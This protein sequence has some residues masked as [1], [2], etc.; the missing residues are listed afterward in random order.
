MQSLRGSIDG[1]ERWVESH[2]YKAYEPFDGLS[3]YL[4]PLTFGNRVLEQILLQ[5]GRQSPIN[6]RPL[7]GIKP[8]ESTKGR[9]Y[10]AWG[11][12]TLLK[13]TGRDEYR[14][15]A[16][17]CLEWLIRN[18]SPLY[19]D[20]SWG[21][22]F[23]YAS[24]GG[25]YS[26]HEP[27]IVWTSLIGQAFLDGYETLHDDRYLE[28][29]NSICNWIL[30]VPREKTATGTCLSYFANRLCS[31]HNSNML[32]AAMLAR[33][34]RHTGVIELVDVAKAAMEYSCS[35]Q[36]PNGAWYYGEDP[37][38]RWIDNFHTGY[39]LDSLKSYI[40]STGD[41]TFSRHLDLGFRYFKTNFF[42]PGGRPK[43]YHNRV[44]PIDIQCASQAIETLANFSDYDHEAL[45]I[46]T[47]VAQWT[48]EHMQNRTGYFYYRRYPLLVA[49]IAM[50]HWG[51]AT[52]FRALSLLL[53]RL[54]HETENSHLKQ[55]A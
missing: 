34:A 33:T 18:R 21:N 39:N 50:L 20:A 26:K 38:Y 46:A 54:Q 6:F 31:V 27:I 16:T 37:T 43:Y 4:R 1:L 23:D 7:L 12:L 28:I 52:M 2:D 22:H 53:L 9:G 42:E 29:A 13:L 5:I 30:K 48:I 44:Y 41:K 11:Y 32:G 14:Q 15:K 8:L 10:M 49:K 35:H 55:L 40:E 45:S 25:T 19:P 17:A 24:R 47:K 36:L 51:Q 3:S